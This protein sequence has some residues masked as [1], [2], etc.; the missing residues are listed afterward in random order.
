[1]DRHMFDTFHDFIYTH[2]LLP[3]P[4]RL[5]RIYHMELTMDTIRFGRLT[6]IQGKKGGRYPFCNSLFIDDREKV[7]IDPGCGK[8][9]LKKLEAEK[10][11]DTII[12]SHYHE[13]HTA[14]NY[15]FPE[16][17]LSVPADEAPCFSSLEKLLDFS[18][19]LGTH[20]EEKW[21]EIF[22]NTFNYRERIPDGE[23]RDG[24]LLN[25]GDTTLQ[26]I[27]TPG[28]T[29]GHSSFFFPDEKVL[30]MGDL[31]LT[32][33]GPWYGDRVSDIDQTIASLQRLL[34]IPARIFIT[35]HEVGILKGDITQQ[36]EDYCA[37]IDKRE[38]ILLHFLETPRTVDEIVNQ[39][40][41]YKKPRDP[42]EYFEAGERGMITKHLDRLT[43][44]GAVTI[45]EGGRYVAV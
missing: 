18:G 26:V 39:W 1:M 24:D 29:I 8:E 28:H 27:H 35:S 5:A 11:I 36:V 15:L 16:A 7:I 44:T 25:F 43:K 23:F 40:I 13:D 10:G 14:F 33:F 21:R 22:L 20:L 37:I 38:N 41:I 9:P 32:P 34:T 12:N 30:F 3:V 2:I 31:D 19:M 45:E 4:C 6:F 17:K 42:R